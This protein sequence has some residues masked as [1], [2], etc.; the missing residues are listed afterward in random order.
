M[1]LE[2]LAGKWGR[3]VRMLVFY[4][5]KA[6]PVWIVPVIAAQIIDLLS[7]K[8]SNFIVWLISLTI[9]AVFLYL[10]N[11]PGHYLYT[12]DLSWLTR[13][14]GRDLRIRLCRQL[15][16]LSITYHSRSGVGKLHSKAIRDIEIIETVP[17]LFIETVVNFFVGIVIAFITVI[18]R[19]PLALLFFIVSVP[20]VVWL[21]HIFYERVRQ[22][23]RQYRHS[24]EGMSA[25][26]KDMMDMILITRAHGLEEK[27]LSVMINKIGTVLDTGRNFDAINAL[28]SASGWATMQILQM[29]FLTGSAYAA[30]KGHI[31]VGD[32]VMFNSFFIILSSQL[33]SVLGV[34]PQL[35]Q[36]GESFSSVM[37][38]LNAP[39]LE[40]N[41][42]KEAFK[43][44][45]GEYEFKDVSFRYPQMDSF[46]IQQI[47]LKI[48]AGQSIAIIG[49]SGSGKTTLLA[50]ALGFLR[51]E[52]GNIFIDGKDIM[53]MDLRT[54]RHHV[55]VVTQEPVFFSGTVFENVAY[56][57][58]K[59]AEDTVENALTH[60]HAID[61]VRELPD[62]MYTR[63]G[64]GG[65]KFS[66]GQTQLLAIA[67]AILRNP[68][69]LILDEATSSI[70]IDSEQ[71]IQEAIKKL[72]AD[73]TTFVISH[74]PSALRNVDKVVVL[75]QGR[76][77]EIITPG[78]IFGRNNNNM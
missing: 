10:Q 48:E 24:V 29:L 1:I 51:P 12:K 49:P 39:D 42:G 74:R 34:M 40:C 27:Q 70:D 35:S 61:F 75:N 18:I 7:K 71:L 37:E 52:K 33:I 69:V 19:S 47:S 57:G 78:E 9:L 53:A 4:I 56:G 32:V 77:V 28:F 20:I 6:S 41:N 17:R 76:I 15:Q 14:I 21:N 62:G 45:K 36:T 2:L 68:K 55:S 63:I 66:V 13:G 73:R 23:V 22:K 16:N 59:I 50:L 25:S 65:V 46:A 26:L 8:D 11:I 31:T 43:D 3:I 64:Q 58:E 44:I 30:F 67:R 72:M 60:A 38:I 5:I 54:Y